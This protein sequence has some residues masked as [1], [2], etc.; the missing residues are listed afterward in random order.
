MPWAYREAGEGQGISSL[1]LGPMPP[2]GWPRPFPGKPSVPRTD[3]VPG[4]DACAKSG[5][6]STTGPRIIADNM[7]VFFC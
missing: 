4:L 7:V 3:V 2:A 5:P 6:L 1:G